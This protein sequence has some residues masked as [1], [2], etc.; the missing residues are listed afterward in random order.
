MMKKN[1]QDCGV[2]FNA[3]DDPILS[4]FALRCSRCAGEREAAYK[5]EQQERLKHEQEQRWRQIC[6]PAYQETLVD[7]LPDPARAAEI[8]AWNYGPTGLL[9]YGPTRR[10]KTRCAWLL[11][12]KTFDAGKSVQVLDSMAG[13]D[14]GGAFSASAAQAENWVY[15]RCRSG[16]LFLDDVF[17]GKLT[18]SFES[19]VFAIV[20]Y[21]L[22]H[23]L[24]IVATLNDTGETL[25]ARM[26]KD[27]GAALVARLKEMCRTIEF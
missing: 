12:R 20:D 16:L 3:P 9:L 15:A 14:Y 17:K 13:F 21:R 11:A 6:P 22:A 5:R 26:S 1:C 7:K 8:L 2:E 4:R 24:P 10:G 18:D 23:R 27:R 19:A 25:A